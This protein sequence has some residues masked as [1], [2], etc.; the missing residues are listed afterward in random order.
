MIGLAMLGTTLLSHARAEDLSKQWQLRV[1]QRY[2]EFERS[3][4]KL[5][6]AI[7]PTDPARAELLTKAFKESKKELVAVKLREL[8]AQIE[9]GEIK[10]AASQ[11][12]QV[13][14]D[15]N[16]VLQLLLSEDRADRVE[17]RRAKLEM[18]ARQVQQLTDEQRRLR[19]STEKTESSAADDIEKQQ[20]RLAEETRRMRGGDK[21]DEHDKSTPVRSEEKKNASEERSDQEQTGEKQPISSESTPSA[22]SSNGNKSRP[23]SNKS[24]VK[25]EEQTEPTPPP[26]GEESKKEQQASSPPSMPGDDHLSKAEESMQKARQKI[27]D[28]E[29][30]LALREQDKALEELEQSTKELKKELEELR[31]EEKKGHLSDLEARLR[32]ILELEKAIYDGTLTLDKSAGMKRSRSDE[33]QGLA[34]SRSQRE[35]V[36][37]LDQVLGILLADGTAVAFPET[38][39]QLT[40]DGDDV[41]KRLAVCDT[42]AFTQ[43]VE[44]DIL[45]SLSEMIQ[46]LQRE[47]GKKR[48]EN[49]SRKG[50]S[51]NEDSTKSPLVEELSE[52]KMIRSLQHR[53]NERTNALRQSNQS[54]H[55]K[56]AELDQAVRDLADRQKRVYQITRDVARERTP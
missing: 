30:E 12:D 51:G 52:L 13:I 32:Q 36:G 16:G 7:R 2:R 34:L 10:Q 23:K 25:Q 50:E 19:S 1:E 56:S 31:D 42:G 54:G 11:Q 9:K 40:R 35:I 45:D 3:L 55:A 53:I 46:S 41:A 37:Q 28:K 26:A 15:M 14:A 44:K 27:L 22:A 6:N 5:A 33:Q 39:E 43:H 24:S 18:Y 20:S 8:I 49:A 21:L 47:L 38:I 17:E 48:E 4:E 29:K